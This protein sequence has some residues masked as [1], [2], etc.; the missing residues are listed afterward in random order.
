MVIGYLCVK[1]QALA[2][3]SPPGPAGRACHMYVVD[4]LLARSTYRQTDRETGVCRSCVVSYCTRPCRSRI[5]SKGCTC[6]NQPHIVPGA[7]ALLCSRPKPIL[8]QPVSSVS[9]SNVCYEHPTSS[10]SMGKLRLRGAGRHRV[11]HPQGEEAKRGGTKRRSGEDAK[12]HAVTGTRAN[13]V[14]GTTLGGAAHELCG[15]MR[16]GRVVARDEGSTSVRV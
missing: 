1:L 7:N 2:M 12:M 13:G 8:S 9:Q 3:D 16:D 10:S 6:R 5:A 11:R 15:K 4:S 14:G